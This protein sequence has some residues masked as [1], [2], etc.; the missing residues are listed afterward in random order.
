MTR[1]Q[2]ILG[3]HFPGVNNMTVW[4]DPRAGSQIDFASF[5]RFTQAA[6]RGKL[7]FIFLA[8]G[9]RLREQRGRLHD[10][11][12]VGRPNTL[13]VLAA[14][15]AVTSRIGLAGT[16]NATFNE[17]YN[18]ARQLATLDHLSAG[19]AAWNVVTSPGAFTG[20]NFRRGAYLPFDQ[21]YERAREF[22]SL[23]RRLW[24]GGRHDIDYQGVHFDI[25]G[26]Y[27]VPSPPQ[28]HP[29]IFQAGDS[30]AGR[31]FAAGSADAI[32]TRHGALA[33]GQAFHADVK[34]RLARYGRAPGALKILPGVG[35]VLGDTAEEATWRY[36]EVRRQQ[37]SPQTAIV[38]L[39]QVWNRDLSAYDPEGP[40]PDVEPDLEGG[41]VAK[42]R[43]RQHDDN[44]A[45]ARRWRELARREGLGIR[46]L[47]IRVTGR[48][49]F[50]GTPAQVA[51]EIDRYVQAD[52][53]DGFIIAPH[54][55]PSGIEEFVD[56]VVPLLREKGVFRHDYAG[57]T[58]REHLG[59]PPA[60][61]LSESRAEALAH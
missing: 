46:D 28:G 25:R 42:G 1:K 61:R 35:V 50:V 8:E 15:A 6:E 14:L 30:D 52:A 41:T 32:F 26:R 45:T 31:E 58:L 9:L 54:L 5:K 2:I 11:D 10:L 38:L 40:L 51:D 59:L 49:Q 12:V 4:S 39:E 21:R 7:D 48:Q 22:V 53:A 23:A 36:A 34:R 56:R 43:T 17:P 55:I 18:L 24:D 20:E 13:A 3:A 57:Q 37:V 33:E 29:V 47:I 27:D 19:R 44:L 16:L 60:Q